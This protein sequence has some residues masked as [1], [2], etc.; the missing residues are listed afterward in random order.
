MKKVTTIKMF[1]KNGTATIP[2]GWYK[3][4][5][6]RSIS[7][8]WN[9]APNI[10]PNIKNC[11]TIKSATHGQVTNSRGNQVSLPIERFSLK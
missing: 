5:L 9:W 11:S 4:I 3:V 8:G 6:R 1:L 7:S 2:T 10:A